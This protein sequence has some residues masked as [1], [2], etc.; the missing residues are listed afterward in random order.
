MLESF[1]RYSQEVIDNA[2]DPDI[3]RVNDDIDARAKELNDMKL[4][5]VLQ[6]PTPN[7]SPSNLL[8]NISEEITN[9]AVDI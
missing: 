2:T 4:I 9:I 3:A 5:I 8:R 7:F 6:L 1:I